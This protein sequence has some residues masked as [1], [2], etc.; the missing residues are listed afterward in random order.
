MTGLDLFR[1]CFVGLTLPPAVARNGHFGRSEFVRLASTKN[2]FVHPLW[3]PCHSRASMPDF[4]F[5]A[6]EER[7]FPPRPSRIGQSDSETFSDLFVSL[8]TRVLLQIQ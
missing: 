5:T 7:P 6:D 8:L 4:V 2:L 3:G 1:R